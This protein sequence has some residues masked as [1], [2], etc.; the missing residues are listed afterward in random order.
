MAPHCVLTSWRFVRL[1]VSVNKGIQYGNWQEAGMG[2]GK[3]QL[4]RSLPA[5][6]VFFY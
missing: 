1:G 6:Q 2:K 5:I 3:Q 4:V